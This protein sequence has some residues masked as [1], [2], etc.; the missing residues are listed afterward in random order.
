MKSITRR[1]RSKS[2]FHRRRR[3]SELTV[4]I[5]QIPA[6]AEYVDLAS[7]RNLSRS[8]TDESG[9]EL[10]LDLPVPK[11]GRRSPPVK[12]NV[13]QDS[14]E[15]HL[16]SK[17][18]CTASTGTPSRS[19]STKGSPEPK[20][21]SQRRRAFKNRF[22]RK[23]EAGKD[24]EPSR[25]LGVRSLLCRPGKSILADNAAFPE[26]AAPA[27]LLG[28]SARL[29]GRSASPRRSTG[30]RLSQERLG[31]QRSRGR[32]PPTK[33]RSSPNS[34]DHKIL[35]RLDEVSDPRNSDEDEP[36]A[37]QSSRSRSRSKDKST[38]SSRHK[39]S[40]ESFR[41]P[42]SIVVDRTLTGVSELSAQVPRQRSLGADSLAEIRR[43]LSD[44]QKEL[45]SPDDLRSGMSR[46]T[47]A[48][49]LMHVASTLESQQDREFLERKLSRL[50]QVRETSPE[51]PKPK[52][53]AYQ[54]RVNRAI[55]GGQIDPSSVDQYLTYDEDDSA[56]F[57]EWLN[58]GVDDISSEESRKKNAGMGMLGLDF[59]WSSFGL[60]EDDV[61]DGES[62]SEEGPRPLSSPHDASF[63]TTFNNTTYSS[64]GMPSPRRMRRRPR[65]PPKHDEEDVLTPDRQ[66]RAGGGEKKTWR[67][68]ALI[69]ESQRDSRSKASRKKRSSREASRRLRTQSAGPPLKKRPWRN[70][71][72]D[73]ISLGS[74]ESSHFTRETDSVENILNITPNTPLL[75]DSQTSDTGDDDDPLAVRQSDVAWESSH[76]LEVGDED[77]QAATGK[78]TGRS[79][80]E[81][82]DHARGRRMYT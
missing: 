20:S 48:K 56:A 51:L 60:G 11:W 7:G 50:S 10:V 3:P 17:T 64:E 75:D 14:P 49:T 15:S 61:T 37:R 44:V 82:R 2:P 81:Q 71:G 33:R 79:R 26:P 41:R 36:R 55:L 8:F 22:M 76:Y 6:D 25:R 40:E 53:S 12:I 39:K 16:D 23:D 19:I 24:E 28:T 57:S 65:S 52:G 73:D 31:R 27:I 58:G 43:A 21:L 63:D 78:L 4:G 30:S 42:S 62:W 47:I 5:R 66:H 1:V 29:R 45:S 18:L 68:H 72:S 35:A 59:L 69:H 70:D 77:F 9:V 80:W 38:S 46:E 13:H 74:I 32:T 34:S 67:D 54:R